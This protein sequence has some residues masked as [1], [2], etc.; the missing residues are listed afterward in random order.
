MH[1]KAPHKR[2]SV[3]KKKNTWKGLHHDKKA[4]VMLTWLD[5]VT[6]LCVNEVTWHDV[7]Q[8]PAQPAPE[9]KQPRMENHRGTLFFVLF[10]SFLEA[11]WEIK[12]FYSMLFWI[13]LKRTG[14]SKDVF[15]HLYSGGGGSCVGLCVCLLI[16][17]KTLAHQKWWQHVIPLVM[18]EYYH[19]MQ[20]CGVLWLVLPI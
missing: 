4:P 8:T 5:T 6:G 20:H 2:I 11:S 7:N 15:V 9:S 17:N 18:T 14:S 16:E 1:W 3:K 19:F 13:N 10:Y 12:S